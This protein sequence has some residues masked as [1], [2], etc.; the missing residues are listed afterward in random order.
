MATEGVP[1]EQAARRASAQ[2]VAH[3]NVHD[4]CRGVEAAADHVLPHAG[5]LGVTR[6]LAV[7]LRAAGGEQLSGGG[8]AG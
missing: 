6:H 8:L 2:C 5:K 1:W 3:L 4:E 7:L